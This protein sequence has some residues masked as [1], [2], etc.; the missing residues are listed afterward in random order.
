MR[1]RDSDLWKPRNPITH[2]QIRRETLRWITLP[3]LIAAILVVALSVMVWLLPSASASVWA[4]IALIWMLSPAIVV[5]LLMLAITAGSI[6]LVVRLIRLLPPFFFK[7]QNFA[8]LFCVRVD[9]I[10]NRM[11]APVIKANKLGAQVR[12]ARRVTRAALRRV[13]R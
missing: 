1:E 8:R 13:R 10:G 7:A 12:A 2:R 11:T 5:T 4:D 6:Y 3:I 9:Q